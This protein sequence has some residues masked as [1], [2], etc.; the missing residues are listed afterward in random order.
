MTMLDSASPSAIVVR[1]S[2]KLY[3]KSLEAVDF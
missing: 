2:R 3:R 1:L